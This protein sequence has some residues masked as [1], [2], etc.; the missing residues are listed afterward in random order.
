MRN[1]LTVF[2]ITF[3][4]I[5]CI[6]ITGAKA[7][8]VTYTTSTPIPLTLTDWAA[9]YSLQ[10]QKFN[11]PNATLTDMELRL[12]GGMETIITV[13]NTGITPV[14]Y[15]TAKTELMMGVT[16][17]LNLLPSPYGSQLDISLPTGSGYIY[18]TPLLPLPPGQTKVSTLFNGTQNIFMN[19]NDPA[20]LA[21]FSGT[22]NIDLPA[23]SLTI[24]WASFSGGNVDTSQTTRGSLT[25]QVTYTYNQNLAVPETTSI[26]FAI[27]G[28]AGIVILC[29]RFG[30]RINGAPSFTH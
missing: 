2:S 24:S 21:Q 26:L 15:G 17:P 8:T 3:F 28:F 14:I 18:A 30:S 7:D 20:M 29:K 22:G 11:V 10:F 16:D 5:L 27:L 13:K 12:T 25:G 6:A 4:L 1:K 9:V 23:S 19:S